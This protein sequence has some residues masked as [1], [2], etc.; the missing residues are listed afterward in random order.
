MTF[1]VKPHTRLWLDHQLFCLIAITGGSAKQSQRLPCIKSP[2]A[3]SGRKIEKSKTPTLRVTPK[4]SLTPPRWDLFVRS[5]LIGH[6]TAMITRFRV[7]RL[8]A[9][10][11]ITSIHENLNRSREWNS[12]NRRI[13]SESAKTRSVQRNDSRPRREFVSFCRGAPQWMPGR[14]VAHSLSL[15]A[16][17]VGWCCW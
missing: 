4:F 11:I 17:L 14:P 5:L 16:S 9:M 10:F 15:L 2:V 7:L 1:P 3:S 8:Q 12:G 13:V 6:L